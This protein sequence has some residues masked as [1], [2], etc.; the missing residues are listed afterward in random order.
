MSK[1]EEVALTTTS[2]SHP[3]LTSPE[4][5]ITITPLD[6]RQARFASALRGFDKNDVTTFLQ[7]AA[8]GFDEALREN[9]RLRI[10]IARL[11]TSLNHFRQLEENLKSTIQSAQRMADDMRDKAER[12]ATRI[13]SDA[14]ERV[15]LMMQKAQARTEDI[16]REIDGLRIKRR[17]AE[18]SVEATI[19]A[20]HNTLEFIREQERREREER[21][22]QHRPKI[23]P[24]SSTATRL[25]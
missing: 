22:L 24:V 3:S 23:A 16:E 7:E 6:M 20:L 19:A 21:V 2:D 4:R 12:E 15:E 9:E 11:Q 18:V 8:Q 14:D 5:H 25:G 1:I 17:E 10:E 13:I